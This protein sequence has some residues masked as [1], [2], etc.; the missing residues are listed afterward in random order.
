MA[1]VPH[2]KA[3]ANGMKLG[4]SASAELREAAR[5]KDAART[6]KDPA[7]AARLKEA[8]A[9]LDEMKRLHAE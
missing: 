2:S 3:K 7:T 6:A 8:T 9:L 1:S 5:L 4:Q